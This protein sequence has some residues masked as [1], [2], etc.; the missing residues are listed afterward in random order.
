MR[1]FKTVFLF[2]FFFVVAFAHANDWIRIE[3]RQDYSVYLSRAD[4]AQK[5][6][7]RFARFVQNFETAQGFEGNYY[8]SVKYVY[9]I[10]CP[11]HSAAELSKE[12]VVAWYGKGRSIFSRK[13]LAENIRFEFIERASMLDS[14][15]FEVCGRNY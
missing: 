14:V 7:I 9:L 6:A 12:G 1:F 5:E 4:K 15:F 11:D 8:K 2:S 10:S 13:F 3:K